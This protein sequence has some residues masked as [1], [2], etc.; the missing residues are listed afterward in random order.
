MPQ[1]LAADHRV[2]QLH[3]LSASL[4]DGSL[5]GAYEV[6]LSFALV[7]VNAQPVFGLAYVGPIQTGHRQSHVLRHPGTRPGSPKDRAFLLA[8][9]AQRLLLTT[10]VAPS[11]AQRRADRGPFA[12]GVALPVLPPRHQLGPEEVAIPV[13]DDGGRRT[14]LELEKRGV[15][16]WDGA[17]GH[18]LADLRPHAPQQ[19]A[20]KQADGVDLVR[21]LPMRDAPALRYVELI[22]WCAGVRG[23]SIQSEYDQMFRARSFPYRPD[24]I[25]RRMARIGSVNARV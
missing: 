21:T 7:A 6:E 22:R 15:V 14:V 16:A 5:V 12:R 9:D 4:R 24:S 2:V 13:V 18:P 19:A 1:G 17:L 8:T 25:T 11:G 23:R 3:Q 20:A 10:F